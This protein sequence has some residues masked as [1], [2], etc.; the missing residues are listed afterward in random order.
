MAAL[1]SEAFYI[2]ALGSRKTHAARLERLGEAGFG[3]DALKRIHGPAGLAIGAANPA[4]I[5]L[6][7]AAQMVSAWREADG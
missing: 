1:N 7:V 6:S 3:D 5:A 2:A 4:E